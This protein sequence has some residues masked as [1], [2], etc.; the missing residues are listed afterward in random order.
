LIFNNHFKLLSLNL[1]IFNETI[2]I[3]ITIKKNEKTI[4]TIFIIIFEIIIIKIIKI[5]KIK[6]IKIDDDIFIILI[7]FVIYMK[8]IQYKKIYYIQ[9]I[10]T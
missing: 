10:N 1:T 2:I 3:A 4:K 5:I 6:I 8:K 7:S 9:K